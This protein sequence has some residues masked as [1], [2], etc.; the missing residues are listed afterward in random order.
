[1]SISILSPN[2][3]AQKLKEGALLI[4]IRQLNEYRREHIQNSVQ[5]TPEQL[6][7]NGLPQEAEQA[8]T[9]IFHCRSGMRT[10]G[11]AALLSQCA[12]GK[13]C[14]ILQDGIDGWK[15]AGLSTYKDQKQPL[16]LMR[17]VQIAAGLMILVG[18]LAGWFIHLAFFIISGFV[19]AG[20]LFA[21]ITGFCGLARLLQG[22][23]WNRNY[24]QN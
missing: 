16:E 3:V 11:A 4:D 8:S 24:L 15:K 6:S 22:M 7:T 20:L 5:C 18:V 19:G 14:Y 9:I 13:E 12:N 17:Q 23:P 1:M 10:G 21:G 2:D